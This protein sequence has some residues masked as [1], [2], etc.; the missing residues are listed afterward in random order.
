MHLCPAVRC[1]NRQKGKKRKVNHM[2]P[3]SAFNHH[4]VAT[5]FT[6]VI[7]SALATVPAHIFDGTSS[8]IHHNSISSHPFA[9]PFSC[10]RLGF[11]FV[12]AE[13]PTGHCSSCIGQLLLCAIVWQRIFASR[14]HGAAAVSWCRAHY[15][16]AHHPLTHPSPVSLLAL[17]LT[18][19]RVCYTHTKAVLQSSANSKPHPLY[20]CYLFAFICI[21]KLI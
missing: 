2:G 10:N 19:A 5:T 11:I 6:N 4:I 15:P 1:R 18:C 3:H 21:N 8:N 13:A 7:S 16:P 12:P 20:L 14:L 17:R 9:P